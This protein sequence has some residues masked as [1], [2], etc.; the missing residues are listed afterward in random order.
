M[1]LLVVLLAIP[2]VTATRIWIVSRQDD[3][4]PADV[5]LVLGAAQFNGTPSP[6]LESRLRHA[7]TLYEDDVAPKIMTLGGK[8]PG[9]RFTEAAAGKAYLVSR[10]VP[11]ADVI[12]VPR[13][14]NTLES[15]NAAALAMDRRGMST[16]VIVTDPD[17]S[18]RTRTMGRDLG[19]KAWTSPA[20]FNSSRVSNPNGAKYVLRETGAYLDY[21]LFERRGVQAVLG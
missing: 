13:G 12:A 15:M 1:V 4:A 14:D 20:R 7:Q 11:A 2:L 3:R 10:G 8:L 5:L 17:H 9:D 6:V 21:V 16:A 18:L 19:M